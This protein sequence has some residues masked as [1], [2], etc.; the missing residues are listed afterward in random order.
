[1]RALRI[2]TLLAGSLAL[3]GALASCGSDGTTDE[4][5]DAGSSATDGAGGGDET[6]SPRAVTS[7]SA[8][9]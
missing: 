6:E 2:L 9:R 4:K 3:A 8:P 7:T 5:A 1:M